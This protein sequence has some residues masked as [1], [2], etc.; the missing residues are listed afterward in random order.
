VAHELGVQLSF[1]V[2]RGDVT[3]AVAKVARRLSAD[4]VVVGRSAKLRHQIAGSFSH[5]LTSRND[6]PVV[7]VVP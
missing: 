5:R 7:V 3:R 1:L 2:E 4:L 6:A